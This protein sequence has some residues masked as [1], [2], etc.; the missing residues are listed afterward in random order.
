MEREKVFV[1]GGS[2][3]VATELIKDL[4]ADGYDV[5]AV[6]RHPENIINLE[7]VS[8]AKLDLYKATVDEMVQMITGY[9]IVYF[10]ASSGGGATSVKVDGMGAIKTMMAAQRTGVR[11][12]VM[13]GAGYQLDFD[14]WK[15]APSLE[16]FMA[17]KF[18]TDT[19]LMDSTT[20]NYT[21]VRPG[22]LTE[23]KGTGNISLDINEQL[24][25]PIP[26]VAKTMA[27]VLKFPNTVNRA[28]E[29]AGGTR[30]IDEVLKDVR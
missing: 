2:G 18:M 6:S 5:K 27:E 24:Y 21:I 17:V 1:F 26:D 25:V 4:V 23:Q 29:M 8:T 7:H 22:G 19:Y 14:K 28:F 13:L 12:Y 30:T 20:L 10:M 16:D 15:E 9:P 3:R 11:R